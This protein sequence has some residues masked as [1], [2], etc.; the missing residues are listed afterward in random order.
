[1][2]FII[3]PIIIPIA[4]KCDKKTINSLIKTVIKIKRNNTVYR[5]LNAP[6][7]TDQYSVSVHRSKGLAYMHFVRVYTSNMVGKNWKLLYFI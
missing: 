3:I 1:M 2:L 6:G 4:M 7:K 5:Y